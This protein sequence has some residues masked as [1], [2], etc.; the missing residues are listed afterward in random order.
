ML[1][2][3]IRCFCYC[4]GRKHS[5]NSS[6]DHRVVSLWTDVNTDRSSYVN[7]TAVGVYEFSSLQPSLQPS[8]TT[9]WL[10]FIIKRKHW[11]VHKSRSSFDN[12]SLIK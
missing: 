2:L 5:P 4:S 1:A 10:L 8:L 3:N 6:E 12:Y 11:E 9:E 7:Q